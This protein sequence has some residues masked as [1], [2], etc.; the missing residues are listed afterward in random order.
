MLSV[1]YVL[2]N[3]GGFREEAGYPVALSAGVLLGLEK[4]WY[5]KRRPQGYFSRRDL[6]AGGVGL[7]LASLIILF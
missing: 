3:K 2:V 6:V 7:A 5:D 1:Q 4:E